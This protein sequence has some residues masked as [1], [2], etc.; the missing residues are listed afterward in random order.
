MYDILTEIPVK[1]AS[2]WSSCESLLE[3]NLP[4]VLP[5][6]DINSTFYKLPG[7]NCVQM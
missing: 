5:H 6:F 1:G 3:T 7:S 2:F 4:Q